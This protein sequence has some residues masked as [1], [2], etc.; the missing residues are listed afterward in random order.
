M[1]EQIIQFDQNLFFGINQGLSNSFFDWLMPA[2][3]NRFFWTPL[4]LFIVI[5]LVRNYRKKGWYILLFAF[6]C[7]GLTDYISSSV[8]K[9]SVG[10]LRP[11]NDPEIK[12][13]VRNL[14]AC[15][16]GYSFPSSHA[17]NHFGLAVF[18]ILVFYYK[19]KLI[20]PVGLFWAISVSF[21]QIYVGVHFPLDIL[22]GAILGSMIAYIMYT[23]LLVNKSFKEWGPGN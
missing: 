5:F 19:W 1:L 10:R 6:L 16:T 4:Y 9:P 23:I 15:G 3:R 14:I 17:A 21:A 20:L 18:L 13:D 22:G 12:K 11:C 2:L 8:I 7:F